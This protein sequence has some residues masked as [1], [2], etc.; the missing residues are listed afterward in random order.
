MNAIHNYIVGS[1]YDDSNISSRS[2]Y[3]V[4]KGLHLIFLLECSV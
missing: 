2:S 1:V 4:K 3:K